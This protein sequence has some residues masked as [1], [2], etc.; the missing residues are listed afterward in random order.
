MIKKFLLSMLL[1]SATTGLFAVESYSQSNTDGFGNAANTKTADMETYGTHLYAGTNNAGGAKLYRQLVGAPWSQVG[2]DGFGDA[3]N[4]EFSS[5]ETFGGLIYVGTT[6]TGTGSVVWSY[7]GTTFAQVN[8]DGF[9]SAT[10]TAATVL[11]TFNG[12]L[13]A[14]VTGPNGLEVWRYNS[15]T[16]WTQVGGDGL[17][18]VSNLTVTEMSVFKNKLYI[19]TSKA[20]A[21]AEVFSTSDGATFAQAG[22]D[23]FNNAANTSIVVGS[24]FQGHLFL[25]TN[26]GEIWKTINGTTFTKEATIAS[27]VNGIVTEDAHT[28]FAGA[29]NG[30]GYRSNLGTNW[31]ETGSF[32][33]TSVKPH[34]GFDT[35]FFAGDNATAGTKIYGGSIVLPPQGNRRR[36]HDGLC[37]VGSQSGNLGGIVIMVI[38]ISTIIV[39]GCLSKKKTEKA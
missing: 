14:G 36:S 15:G 10:N 13:Y 2:T 35:F 34:L 1:A 3:N 22:T 28:L 9:G 18:D 12:N 21:G 16:S 29:S 8:V 23:G 11:E 25:G 20:A 7:N 24:E 33:A 19:S 30:K 32:D 5:L 6:N 37:V 39:V 26:Q 4:V 27:G 31:S 38:M 17:G